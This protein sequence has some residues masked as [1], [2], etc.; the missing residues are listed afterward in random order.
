MLH[1][2]FTISSPIVATT[3][4][5]QK[6]LIYCAGYLIPVNISKMAS[7]ETKKK[8]LIDMTAKN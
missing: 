2:L 7:S 5:P 4:K 1:H 3:V 6:G 8:L